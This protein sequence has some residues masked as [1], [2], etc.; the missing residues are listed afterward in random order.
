LHLLPRR[1]CLSRRLSDS[2]ALRLLHTSSL[3]LRSRLLRLRS[4]LLNLRALLG[5]LGPLLVY[6]IASLLLLELALLPLG[7]LVA[8]GCFRRQLIDLL[9]TPSR[10]GRL[11]RRLSRYR[12]LFVAR[13]ELLVPCRS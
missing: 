5:D 6:L 13:I 9:L 3:R 7:V 12:P 10:I 2:H 11:S 8:A 4:L 1:F